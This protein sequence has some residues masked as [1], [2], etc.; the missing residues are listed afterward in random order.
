MQKFGGAAILM[1]NPNEKIRVLAG[2]QDLKI[3]RSPLPPY[4]DVSCLFL[5]RLSA[6]LLLNI[7][8]KSFPD[9]VSFAFWCRKANIFKLKQQFI[10]SYLRLGRGY[11]FHIAPSNVPINFAFSFAFSLL[12]GNS[13]IIRVPSKLFR[14]TDLVTLAIKKLMA[15]PEFSQIAQ[16]N[17]FVQ[18]AQDNETT[19]L[20]SHNCDARIIWGGDETIRNIRTLPIPVKSIEIAFA[21][22]YSFCVIDARQILSVSFSELRQLAQRFFN[23]T[24]LM[25][26]NACSSPH[27]VVWLGDSEAI[28]LAKMKFWEAVEECVISKYDLQPVNVIDKYT[29]F[30]SNAI[31]LQE[32]SHFTAYGNHIYCAD[33]ESLPLH[34]D[35]WRGRYGFFYEYST[36]QLDSVASIINNKYQTLTYYGIEKKVLHDFV[37]NN[38]L[39]GIDRIVPI[40]SA[41]DISIV[42]DGYDLVRTLSRICDIQ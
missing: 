4:E 14:Q 35:L 20:L 18:Y 34:M 27:L 26:Q 19:Q 24:Y 38:A 39:N 2:R 23:D 1:P 40:G 16:R 31:L 42:W 12:A 17:V 28:A 37:L 36:D 25:D 32:F 8:V 9:V 22:R 10:D 7:E 41:L 13:N 21:D 6:E 11:V 3:D 29:D 30:C 5:S 15:E 33:L